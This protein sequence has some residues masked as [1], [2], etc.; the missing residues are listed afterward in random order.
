MKTNPSYIR[1]I[2]VALAALLVLA[3]ASRLAAQESLVALGKVS[4]AGTLQAS[5]NTLGGVVASSRIA[6]GNFTVTVTSAGAFAGATISDFLVSTGI[7]SASSSDR[8][9]NAGIVS[10]TDDLLTVRVRIAD[11]ESTANLNAAVAADANFFFAIRRI[12]PLA[13]EFTDDSRHLLAVGTVSSGGSLLS[14]FGV[15]GITLSSLRANT[16]DYFVTLT[17]AGAFALDAAHDYLVFLSLIGSGA[18]D[19]AIRG[20]VSSVS[21]DDSVA[22]NLH[23]DDVQDPGGAD[24]ATPAN[25]NFGFAIYR[26]NSIDL[27]GSPASQLFAAHASVNGT[28]GDLV[29]GQSVFPGGSVSSSRLSTGRYQIDFV[30]P[31]AFV[32]VAP[33]R[34]VP[35]VSLNATS[36][37]DEIAQ[38]QSSVLDANTLRVLVAVNDVQA[39]GVAAGVADDEEFFLSLIDTAPVILHDLSLSTRNA[40]ATFKGAGIINLTGIGQTVRLRLVRTAAKRVFFHSEN[41]G[42][43][44]DDLRLRGQAFAGRLNTRFFDTTVGRRNI[45]A[46]VKI[47]AVAV[48]GLRPGEAVSIES[49]IRYKKANVTPNLTARLRA[50]SGSVP[51]RTDVNRVLVRAR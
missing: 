7:E 20:A 27:T 50:R 44:I 47:G 39:S 2:R 9:S 1:Q 22:F 12:D 26:L 5:S 33:S 15:G 48:A 23:V 6:A 24:L 43:S 49:V 42:A 45:T 31:G 28:T 46:Q 19:E 14:G 29:F 17:K 3:G 37:I 36:L 13:A 8:S 30:S 51:V 35:F 38:A 11:V 10:V 34:F 41:V 40:P 25:R 21:S 18:E 4:S 32:G 16:G